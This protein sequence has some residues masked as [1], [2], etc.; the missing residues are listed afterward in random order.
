MTLPRPRWL[1]ILCVKTVILLIDYLVGRAKAPTRDTLTSTIFMACPF[2]AKKIPE[3]MS[4]IVY[5]RVRNLGLAVKPESTSLFDPMYQAIDALD[6]SLADD[7]AADENMRRDIKQ[8]GA[9]KLIP[10]GK[11]DIPP[12]QKGNGNDAA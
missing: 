7:E 2:F 4:V 3:N 1:R 9:F 11:S 12:K 8:R 5:A 10:G 6:N